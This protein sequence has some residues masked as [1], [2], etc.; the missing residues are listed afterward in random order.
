MSSLQPIPAINGS[1]KCEVDEQPAAR[2]LDPRDLSVRTLRLKGA[3]VT[4][5]PRLWDWHSSV[6]VKLWTPLKKAVD[7]KTGT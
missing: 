2:V 6:T 1:I 3:H 7:V 5:R 4:A